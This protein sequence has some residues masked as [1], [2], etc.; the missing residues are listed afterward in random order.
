[1]AF[2][3]PELPYPK[4]ALAPYISQETLEFHHGKHHAAYVKKL[5][6]LTA[7]SR[8]A[9]LPVEEIIKTA[10]PGPIFN[11][12]AQH[13]NHSFY[14]NCMKPKGGGKP[15]GRIAQEIKRG[16]GDFAQF[17]KK[18]TDAADSLFGSGW[19]WLVQKADGSLAVEP[20]LDADNPLTEN[21]K[22]LFTCDVWEHAYYIDYRN[23]RPKY[24]DA[25]WN[26]VNWEFVAS[27]L[28]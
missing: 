11:N 21:A 9:E 17:Q 23:E 6:E 14:W 8:F 22:P 7:G 16:F 20:K 4:N 3:L 25:F 26:L 12:A 1:M 27:N 15:S 18:F 2:K 13:F 5:N 24:V 10:G 28:K 19:A